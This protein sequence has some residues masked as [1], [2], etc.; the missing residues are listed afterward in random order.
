MHFLQVYELVGHLVY[1]A[2][3]TIIYPLCETNVYVIAP[4][5]PLHSHSPLVD[6]FSAKF[7][8]MSLFEVISDFSLPT[9]IGHLTTPLQ[10]PTRQGT[11]AQMVLWMLQHH[12]LMQLHTYVQFMPTEHGECPA[13]DERDE[14][15]MAAAPITEEHDGGATNYSDGMSEA[16]GVVPTIEEDAPSSVYGGADDA[17]E[18]SAAVSLVSLSSQPMG[19]PNTSR[20]SVTDDHLSEIGDLTTASDDT[21]TAAK[22]GSLGSQKSNYRYVL[23]VYAFNFETCLTAGKLFVK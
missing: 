11:L 14:A 15:A 5:A 22:A 2:K 19:V 3:A 6:K 17:D 7:P 13:L 20:R 9:S 21:T 8:G 16:N 12:L 18:I 10:H 1:W 4:D 23:Y